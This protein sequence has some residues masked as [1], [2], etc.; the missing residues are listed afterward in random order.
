MN[1]PSENAV[2]VHDVIDPARAAALHATLGVGGKAPEQGSHL[3]PLWH[4]VHFWESVAESGL[5]RDGHPRTGG[6]IP[7]TG[8][9]HRMWAGGRFSWHA[10]LIVGVE[11]QKSSSLIRCENKTGRSGNFAIV[12][13]RHEI[14]QGGR[15]CVIEDQ[16]L[17]YR[18]E[19]IRQQ[20]APALAP[21]DETV[22]HEHRFSTVMLFRYSAITFNGH[23][24][25]YDLDFATKQE[26][27]SGLVVHGPL[28]ALLLARIAHEELGS[29]SRFSFRATSPITH[30]ETV[31]ACA[32]HDAERLSLWIRGAGGRLCMSA[33]AQGEATP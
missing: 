11:A 2:V 15:T 9:P 24:I 14:R 6:L 27:Y 32:R 8:F 28:L 5:G 30:E 25:H 1:P 23:R 17:I 29:L 3:P 13:L 12:T 10:P 16:D 31:E 18:E 22:S 33:E 19:K 26:G 7:D 21:L 20:K 4:H